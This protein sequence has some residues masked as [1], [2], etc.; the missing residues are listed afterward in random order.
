MSL[1]CVNLISTIPVNNV[2]EKSNSPC[3]KEKKTNKHGGLHNADY[4]VVRRLNTK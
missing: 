4:Y 3:K 2:P 1:T